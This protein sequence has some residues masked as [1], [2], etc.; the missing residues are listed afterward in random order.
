[1][2]NRACGRYVFPCVTLLICLFSLN[3]LGCGGKKK[4]TYVPRSEKSQVDPSLEVKD[5]ITT[6]LKQQYSKWRGTKYRNGGF[7]RRG[8]DCSGFVQLTYKELFGQNLPRTV[9]QQSAYGRSISRRNLQAGDLVFFKTGIFTRHVGIYMGQNS[10]MHV[11]ESKGLMLS[12]LG[13]EYWNDRY[14]KGQRL[15]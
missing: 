11:S 12:K 8:I 3:L 4:V 10:F 1:M 7:T 9:Q 13:E 14:W 5:E 6:R 2:N 15:L